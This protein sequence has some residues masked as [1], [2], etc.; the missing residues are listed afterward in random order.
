MHRSRQQ[1]KKKKSCSVTWG[2]SEKETESFLTRRWSSINR[3]ALPGCSS[4]WVRIYNQPHSA[5]ASAGEEP[6]DHA[7]P[8]TISPHRTP[9]TLFVP[10]D[11]HK[12]ITL[13]IHHQV[14]RFP[15]QPPSPS[16]YPRALCVSPPFIEWSKNYNGCM[17]LLLYTIHDA[18]LL[19]WLL[20]AALGIFVLDHCIFFFLF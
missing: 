20:Y 8:R 19:P 4:S 15:N 1:C 5:G 14:S 17:L 18:M 10:L 11:G 12:G 9:L 16:S 2:D 7:L 13:P 6:V 3:L